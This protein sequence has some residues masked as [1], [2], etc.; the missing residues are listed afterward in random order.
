M[1]RRTLIGIGSALALIVVV[2]LAIVFAHGGGS[3]SPKK[4]ALNGTP[5]PGVRRCF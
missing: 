3:S 1:S 4:I 5:T 2:T